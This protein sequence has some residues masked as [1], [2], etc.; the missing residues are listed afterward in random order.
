MT[1]THKF[2][3]LERIR[4]GGRIGTVLMALEDMAYIILDCGPTYILKGKELVLLNWIPSKLGVLLE[5]NDQWEV[6][7][8]DMVEFV[9]AEPGHARAACMPYP[10][11]KV[12]TLEY[13]SPSDYANHLP[14]A[15]N[16]RWNIYSPWRCARFMIGDP[17]IR[18]IRR[19]TQ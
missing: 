3:D 11:G 13:N 14:F 18:L 8:G 7:D 4:F 19:A 12:H 9:E 17:R 6:A 10:Q 16:V 1:L 15:F 2:K 5:Q